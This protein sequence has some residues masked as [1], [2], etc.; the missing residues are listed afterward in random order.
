MNLCEASFGASK[1]LPFYF[2]YFTLFVNEI[3]LYVIFQEEGRGQQMAVKWGSRPAAGGFELA[4]FKTKL[5]DLM[6][7]ATACQ[8]G[9]KS[10]IELTKFEILGDPDAIPPMLFKTS[11]EAL[12]IALTSVLRNIWN[13]EIVPYYGVSH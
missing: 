6:R 2:L 7:L 9:T 8:S 5:H 10:N 13:E 11:G 1:K 4:T 12:M 3:T